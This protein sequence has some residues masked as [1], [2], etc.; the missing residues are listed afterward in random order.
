MSGKKRPHR[1]WPWQHVKS[2]VICTRQLSG[3][4]R[5]PLHAHEAAQDTKSVRRTL[6]STKQKVKPPSRLEAKG[7]VVN[8][9]E[10]G[11]DE[12]ELGKDQGP[13]Q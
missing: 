4:V 1:W 13:I 8:D 10:R 9:Q 3:V 7:T 11:V 12:K 6:Q 5:R 2:V